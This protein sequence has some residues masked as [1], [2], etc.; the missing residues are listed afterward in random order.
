MPDVFRKGV[1]DLSGIA[2]TAPGNLYV[3]SATQDAYVN[4]NE[5]GTEAAAVTTI[6]I[7]REDATVTPK[8]I[9]NHPFI[10]IIQDDASDAILFMGRISDPTS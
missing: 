10:F 7:A 3:T 1:A 6:L 4:V 9:A 5:E 2:D 8:F